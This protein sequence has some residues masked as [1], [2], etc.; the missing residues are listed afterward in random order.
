MQEVNPDSK[1][2]RERDNRNNRLIRSKVST[3]NP[4]VEILNFYALVSQGPT[5]VCISCDQLCYKR[6]VS[7][8][9]NTKLDSI[10]NLNSNRSTTEHNGCV[11]LA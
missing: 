5:Y 10:I 4:D 3:R 1:T 6:S 2:I 11:T 8:K 9:S 7:N